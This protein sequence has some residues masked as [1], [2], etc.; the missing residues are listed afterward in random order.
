MLL[1]FAFIFLASENT[2]N[3]RRHINTFSPHGLRLTRT[4]TASDHIFGGLNFLAEKILTLGE[5]VASGA[6]FPHLNI[7]MYTQA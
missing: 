1:F 7:L 3:E 6:L 2:Y 4:D 5:K